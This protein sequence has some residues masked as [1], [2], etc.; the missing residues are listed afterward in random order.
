[1]MRWSDDL[2][3][4]NLGRVINVSELERYIIVVFFSGNLD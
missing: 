1:M 4:S 3:L 2:Y